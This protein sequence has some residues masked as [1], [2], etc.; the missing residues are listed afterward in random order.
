[1]LAS[2]FV[3]KGTKHQ[4]ENKPATIVVPFDM[5]DKALDDAQ[6]DLERARRKVCV[7]NA[8]QR[9]SAAIFAR[10]ASLP[11]CTKHEMDRNAESTQWWFGE[12]LYV[13]LVVTFELYIVIHGTEG[14]DLNGTREVWPVQ[15]TPF[16]HCKID[17]AVACLLEAYATTEAEAERRAAA[18]REYVA[19]QPARERQRKENKERRE[20]LEAEM[21]QFLAAVVP[22]EQQC[23][24]FMML[25]HS[26]LR[27]MSDE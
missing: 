13:E 5:S 6:S 19:Q 24:D 25:V 26:L 1:M 9:A 2:L 14:F 12:S 10:L 11:A 18:L 23:A 4:I 20:R 7:L 17:Q 16:S 21:A 27:E 15:S 22:H 3:V 8:V